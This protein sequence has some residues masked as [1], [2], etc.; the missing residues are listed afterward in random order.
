MPQE[1]LAVERGSTPTVVGSLS[2][3]QAASPGVVASVLV[4]VLAAISHAVC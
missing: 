2:P 3:V 4:C 1:R